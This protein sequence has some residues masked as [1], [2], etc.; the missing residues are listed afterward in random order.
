M[1]KEFG[2]QVI[3]TLALLLILSPASGQI[4]TTRHEIDGGFARGTWCQAIDFDNDGDPD[5]LAAGWDAGLKWYRNDGGGVFTK[6]TI[7]ND[8]KDAW[9]ISAANLDKDSDL[10]I[11]SVSAN[12]ESGASMV[13]WFETKSTGFQAHELD[14]TVGSLPHSI[15]GIDI[16]GDGDT[17]VLA[18]LSGS[19]K[20]RLW[21]NANGDSLVEKTFDSSWQSGHALSPVDID[22]DG[23]LDIIGIGGGKTSIWQNKGSG[24]FVRQDLTGGGGF[25]I[26]GRDLDLDGNV[27]ILRT[28]RVNGHINW[29]PHQ[30]DFNFDTRVKLADALGESW[31]LDAADF[32]DDGD[33]DLVV[34]GYVYSPNRILFLVNDG[35]QNFS[36]QTIFEAER[37]RCVSAADF[38]LDG[39]IDFAAVV[40]NTS[41]LLWF[42]IPGQ[43]IPKTFTLSSPNGGEA[44]TGG[45]N[46]TILWN[47]TGRINNVKLE[48]ST[49]SG[50]TWTSIVGSTPNVGSHAWTLPAVQ[51]SQ[52]LVRI[53]DAANPATSD[54]SDATFNIVIPDFALTSP[55]GGESFNVNTTQNITWNSEGDIPNV[56]LE[57]SLDNGSNWT[58]V[59]ASTANTGSFSWTVPDAETDTGLIRISDASDGAPS[60]VSDAAFS[61]VRNTITITFPNG[62]ETLPAGSAQLIAW[63]SAGN[64]STVKL[65]YSLNNGVSWTTIVALTANTGSSVWVVP[66]SPNTQ[67]LVRVSNTADPA[68]FDVSD[69]TFAIQRFDNLVLTA[70]NGGE[71][72]Q[73]GSTHNI[74]WNSP[75]DIN[76]LKI[77]YSS[78]NGANWVLIKSSATNTGSY[79][80]LIPSVDTQ[81]ALVRVSDA[82]D[83]TP[84]D[85]SND[86]FTLAG[87][88]E[89]TISA[90]N[91]GEQWGAGTT[92]SVAWSSRGSIPTVSL[93]YSLDGGGNWLG[94]ATGVQNTGT[95][96]WSLPFA[97]SSSC[98]VRI[99]DPSAGAQPD[100]S[101]N[102][103]S[104]I[105]KLELS[106]ASPNG[107]EVWTQGS[108]RTVVWNSSSGIPSV[109]L[110]YSVN[111]GT[112]WTTI[113][114]STSNQGIYQWPVPDRGSN[115]AL[116]R[117][118]KD[119]DASVS[120]VSD[121]PFTIVGATLSLV[122]PNGGESWKVGE[123]RNILWN[124]TGSLSS[125]RIEY[126]TDAG[127]WQEIT[128]STE[129]NSRFDWTVPQVNSS[130]VMVRISDAADGTPA[131]TSDV[132]FSIGTT[133]GVARAGNS[134]PDHFALSQNYPNP[135]NLGTF[136]EFSVPKTAAVFLRVFNLKGELVR[137]LFDDTLTPGQYTALWT[138]RDEHGRVQATGVYVYQVRIGEWQASKKLL[139][140]K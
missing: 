99:S 91:G 34:A 68:I 14:A 6:I 26:L 70:P 65:E 72:W 25:G 60:D 2:N 17:D 124:S 10:D 93:E 112:D 75:P 100:V 114:E 73:Q 125:I 77:E 98:L 39:D 29:Y 106:I 33:V 90:P 7:S 81:E 13:S 22:S 58:V 133:T 134:V 47:S 84:S 105:P 40:S 129:N 24:S 126:S 87:L 61:I 30:G 49:D 5:I 130:N 78:D 120:D 121:E 115:Q 63:Q 138:G 92:Q 76:A 89:L 57:Y 16:E 131:D 108:S 140:V 82:S 128:A 31:S 118:S 21:E 135:F 127:A 104:I 111:S 53:S 107:G 27:D 116:I 139:L 32:D 119:D 48:Y 59:D 43:P 46:H 132:S 4:S 37:P 36:E 41:Q 113:V 52:A 19:N 94:I 51:T 18:A 110:E 97:T 8:F 103:F 86:V 88:P 85:V 96:S 1:L 102:L 109:K 38:D 62:G 28:E 3:S 117:I 64:T 9:F 20:V 71:V 83:G 35:Q 79:A 42:E 95:F 137:T 15:I 54:I 56:K 50:S 55:N 80:W 23:L 122:S 11:L 69:A 123:Q 45:A 74:T 67:A 66:D 101:D 44:L 12:E 136:I